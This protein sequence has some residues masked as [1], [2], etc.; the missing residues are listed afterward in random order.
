MIWTNHIDYS[1]HHNSTEGMIGHTHDMWHS[2]TEGLVGDTQD[3]KWVHKMS[4]AHGFKHHTHFRNF[5]LRQ[6][7]DTNIIMN[8][9]TKKA[10]RS[11][12]RDLY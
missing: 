8:I 5:T 2:T 12:A 6:A 11:G 3:N 10:M 7:C 9:C 1:G 4:I